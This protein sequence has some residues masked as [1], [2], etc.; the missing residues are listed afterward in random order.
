MSP[1]ASSARLPVI[2]ASPI[3]VSPSGCIAATAAAADAWTT[4][5]TGTLSFTCSDVRSAGVG[6]LGSKT[7]SANTIFNDPRFCVPAAATLAPTMA[8]GYGVA[9]S[10]PVLGVASPCGPMIGARGQSCNASV[11]AVESGAPGVSATLLEQNVPN[12]FNPSTRI[13]FT[14]LREARTTLR[15]YAATGRLV[16][17]LLD[18]D[19]P[20]GRH[21]VTWDGLNSRSQRVATGVYFYQLRSGAELETRSMVL[22]K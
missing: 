9:A 5:A 3:G 17:T 21:G 1:V 12:P 14:L 4:D 16:T 20:A 19:M 18:R 11:T 10:S 7:F 15:I 8:G 22:L 2:I 13:E 6:G